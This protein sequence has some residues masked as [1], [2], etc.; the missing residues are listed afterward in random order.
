MRSFISD[1]A[2]FSHSGERRLLELK[3]G[4]NII[5]GDSKTGKSALI[6]I[7]DFCLFSER[8]TIPIGKITEWADRF[9]VV[10]TLI[11]RKIILSRALSQKT[12][13]IIS[14]ESLKFDTKR[15]LTKDYLDSYPSKDYKLVQR[16][17]EQHM[18]LAVNS[19]KSSEMQTNQSAG[20]AS[21]RDCATFMFQ[22]QNLV[23]N[24][25][26]LFYRFE[27]FYKRQKAI[28]DYPIHLGWADAQY[29]FLKR[30]QE[31]ILKEL[32]KS[33][34]NKQQ[35]IEKD[36]KIR[37]LLLGAISNYYN[38]LGLVLNDDDKDLSSL[39]KIA[40]NLPPIP[41]NPYEKIDINKQVLSLKNSRSKIYNELKEINAHIE[42]INNNDSSAN[43]YAKKLAKVISMSEPEMCLENINC[44][45]CGVEQNGLTDSMAII[46]NSREKLVDEL[47]KIG[48]FKRDNIGFYSDLL[49]RK[50]AVVNEIRI[51]NS[52]IND[53]KKSSMVSGDEK[54]RDSLLTLK[55]RIEATLEQTIAFNLNK[56]N[57]PDN[58]EISV[59]LED[60]EKKLAKYDLKNKIAEAN[61]L[62]KNIMN[63]LKLK[64]DFE[65]ELKSC[66]I[67]FDLE[68]FDFYLYD[69]KKITLSEMGSGANWLACHLAL[70][71]AL[72]KLNALEKSSIPTVLFLDQPSQVYFPK[73]SRVF[74]SANKEE[75]KD[76][77]DAETKVDENIKQVLNIFEV[78]NNFLKEME[79]DECIGF[80][81]Q[82]IVLEHADEPE[83]KE[84]VR[85]R[86]SNDGEKLI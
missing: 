31:D 48:S 55:G 84:Y 76:L 26:S 1:I 24:K 53:L 14:I 56:D 13:S 29:Y 28:S 30:R 77:V 57:S 23:A 70:F 42:L 51:I 81:P 74:S 3:E 71:L 27:D 75:L 5:T 25:H 37:R 21:I 46:L 10:Y 7:V 40:R 66:E 82:V 64:L 60:I 45:V 35:K 58:G 19:T 34:V 68:S 6:E 11:D 36:D 49:K 54:L 4:L 2:I 20:K 80:K 17:F 83:L 62:L 78:I 44:P 65:D 41:L 50:N 38:T 32:R 69:R 22:H 16:E 39:K 52:A 8:S 63:E 18:G 72:L 9:C 47:S 59:E 12:K 79:N 15:F 85:A 61:D 33:K 67:R 43:S 73:V 86:W